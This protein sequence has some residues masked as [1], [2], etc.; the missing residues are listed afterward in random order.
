MKLDVQNLCC[1]YDKAKPLQQYIN[2]SLESGEI[3]SV[4]GPNGCGKTTFFKTLLGLQPS[5]G[6]KVLVDGSDIS[7]WN[8][9]QLA[10]TVAYVQQRKEEVFPYRV[11]DYVLLGRVSKGGN[12]R[13]L[14]VQDYAIAEEAMKQMGIYELRE[15]RYDHIS[16]GELQLTLIAKAIAQEPKILILDEPTSALDYGNVVR[17]IRKIRELAK[18]GYIVMMTTHSPDHAF[19]CHSNVLLLRKYEPMI[20][21]R[22]ADIITEKNMHQVFNVR[23]K[24]VEFVDAN[25]EIMRMCAPEF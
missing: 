10:N 19:L 18:Q 15:K 14:R 17:V 6:G 9:R 21:G 13:K 22:A 5:L 7:K 1:G 4:L 24:V 25:H 20:F 3:C 8:P 2:F 12:K 23:V 16:G 11:Q